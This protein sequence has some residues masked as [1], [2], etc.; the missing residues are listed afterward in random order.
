[1]ERL[2][3]RRSAE[4]AGFGWSISGPI[5]APGDFGKRCSISGIGLE[6]LSFSGNCFVGPRATKQISRG[7]KPFPALAQTSGNSPWL[8]TVNES[9]G[10]RRRQNRRQSN[11]NPQL[12][13]CRCLR[14]GRPLNCRFVG[15]LADR[16]FSARNYR[17]RSPLRRNRVEHENGR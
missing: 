8:T 16:R 14:G 9:G 3:R 4:P 6:S 15:Y 1:M 11:A 2:T 17:C 7:M 10:Q 5:S 12:H 13:S